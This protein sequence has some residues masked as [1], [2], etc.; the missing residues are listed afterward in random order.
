VPSFANVDELRRVFGGFLDVVREDDK[1]KM[2]GGSGVIIGYRLTDLGVVLVLDATIEQQSGRHFDYYIDDQKAP[3]PHVT[4]D[5]T[6]ETLDELFSG[7]VHAIQ[8]LATG[9]VKGHGN[10]AAAMKLLPAMA[11]VIPLYKAYRK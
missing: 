8:A 5:M 4:F 2:F 1:T 11:R 9:R 10:V 7:K 3:K 6:S